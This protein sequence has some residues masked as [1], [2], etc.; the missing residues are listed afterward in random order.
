M[1]SR[2]TEPDQ[3]KKNQK[4]NQ[5]IDKYL[6]GILNDRECDVLN[7]WLKEDQEHSDYFHTYCKHREPLPDRELEQSWNIF[8]NKKRM[9]GYA[10]NYQP[11]LKQMNRR[12]SLSAHRVPVM[13]YAAVFL[14]GVLGTLLLKD[15]IPGLLKGSEGNEWVHTETLSGQKARVILPDSSVVWLNSESRLSFPSDFLSLKNR[16][17]KLEGEAFFDVSDQKRKRFTV[18]SR[19]YDVLVKGTKFNVMAYR[20]FNRTETTLVEGSIIVSRGKERIDVHPGERVIY[21]NHYLTRSKAQVRQATLW[22]ENK[23]YFDNIPF[24]ELVRRLER[25]Y[26]VD[27]TL[28]DRSLNDIYYSGYFKNEETIWQVLDVIRMTTPIV[29]E[30]KEFRKITIDRKK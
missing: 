27:I 15:Q 2:G 4:I 5:L 28:L 24:K 18:R 13:K 6:D 26:D 23:F 12:R 9:R 22:K 3:M 8:L 11:G 20:D 30:R 14:V 21:S 25:W 1:Y 16:I 19:D 17:V 10:N 7:E 29:Y